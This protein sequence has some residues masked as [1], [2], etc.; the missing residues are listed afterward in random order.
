M[1]EWLIARARTLLEM[2]N[3]HATA[4][5]KDDTPPPMTGTMAVAFVLGAAGAARQVTLAEI[6]KY[7]ESDSRKK[8]LHRVMSGRTLVLDARLGG[9]DPNGLFDKDA[10]EPALTPDF[11]DDWE[12]QIGHRIRSVAPDAAETAPDWHKPHLFDVRRDDE[13]NPLRQLR[14]EKSENASETEDERALSPRRKQALDEHQDWTAAHARKI[15][16]ALA[17]RDDI[18]GAVILAARLHD[19]GKRAERWQRAFNAPRDGNIYAKTTGPL[20]RALLCGYRH[21]F[22]SLPYVENSDAFRDLPPDLQDLVLHLVAA[23]HGRARPTIEMAGCDDAPPSALAARAREVAQ[24]FAR[25]QKEWGPWGLAWLEA[26]VRAADQQASRKN[27]ER[28]E[29]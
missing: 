11:D 27:D 13:G 8:A 17:L 25:L 20:R 6:A 21:E 10:T 1:A 2:G 22:G 7:G 15:C 28:R 14:V 29:A 5:A 26:L 19:E 24:R 4:E 9:L 3:A 18:S 23:H 16:S 12:R